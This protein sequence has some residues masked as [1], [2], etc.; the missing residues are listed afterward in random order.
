MA[1]WAITRRG[2]RLLLVA[3]ILLAGCQATGPKPFN[4]ARGYI[5]SD[6]GD[7]W[8]VS[9]TDAAERRW[10]EL[11]TRALAACA[12]HTGRSMD[13]LRL[14]AVQR[15]SYVDAVPVDVSYP[16][17]V[18]DTPMSNSANGAVGADTPLVYYQ[19]TTVSR[20]LILR[21]VSARCQPA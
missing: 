8:Q 9:Y 2:G 5:V 12:S 10:S 13:T 4:G 18:L 16:A 7:H 17:G 11:E 1:G 19:N 3:V 21:R 20:T 6:A 14:V 15:D